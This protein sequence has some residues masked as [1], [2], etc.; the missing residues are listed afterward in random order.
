M[1]EVSCICYLQ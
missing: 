1:L